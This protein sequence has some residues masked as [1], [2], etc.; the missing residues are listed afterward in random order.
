[1][2]QVPTSGSTVW[3]TRVPSLAIESQARV[4]WHG[5]MAATTLERWLK[6]NDKEKAN[7]I[8]QLIRAAT[9]VDGAMESRREKECW[10]LP[11]ALSMKV[12]SA[13]V[14]DMGMARWNIPQATNTK[15]VGCRIKNKAKVACYGTPLARSIK[16]FGRATCLKGRECTIGWRASLTIKVSKQFTRES[17]DRGKDRDMEPFSTTTDAGCRA[18]SATIWK[19]DCAWW[20]TKLEIR[21]LSTI[22]WISRPPW[23]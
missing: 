2:E 19:K 11:M 22:I 5:K 8:V 20:L 15:A 10:H 7:T 16:V 1:M 17:G 14:W 13:K 4:N 12:S 6:V 3:S 21:T 18:L 9:R 23:S